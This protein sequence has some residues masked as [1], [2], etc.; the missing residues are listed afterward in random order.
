MS[1]SEIITEAMRLKPQERYKVIEELVRSLDEPDTKIDSIWLKE[2][3]KRLAAYESDSI[4]T[5]SYEAA[6]DSSKN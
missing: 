3:A 1:I 4:K 2:S 6:F 5:V